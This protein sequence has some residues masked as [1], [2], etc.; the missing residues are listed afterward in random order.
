MSEQV[1]GLEGNRRV[2]SLAVSSQK[3]VRPWAGLIGRWLAFRIVSLCCMD[4]RHVM[5]AFY[6]PPCVSAAY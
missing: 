2:A 5:G 4:M 6:G 1:A 3:A